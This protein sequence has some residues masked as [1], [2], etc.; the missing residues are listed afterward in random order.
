MV[1]KYNKE[2]IK[3]NGRQLLGSSPGELQKK[4]TQQSNVYEGLIEDLR[5]EIDDLKK[6]LRNS[7]SKK[8]EMF[9]AEQVDNDINEVLEKTIKELTAKHESRLGQQEA[10]FKESIIVKDDLIADL[11]N[12]NKLLV[13]NMCKVKESGGSE[14]IDKLTVLLKEAAERAVLNQDTVLEPSRPKMKKV[15]IDPLESGMGEGLKSNISIKNI[16]IPQKESV[17]SKVSKLRELLGNS[18][19]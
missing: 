12:Q 2:H 4:Q 7:L 19:I 8:T 11:K 5:E 13:E 1:F 17:E 18:K 9:T 16:S 10:S 3:K 6:K 14:I 15:V